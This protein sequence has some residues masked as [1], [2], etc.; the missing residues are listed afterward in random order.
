VLA[1]GYNYSQR[2]KNN[3]KDLTVKNKIFYLLALSS[4]LSIL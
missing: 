1:A 2:L 3:S 4:G